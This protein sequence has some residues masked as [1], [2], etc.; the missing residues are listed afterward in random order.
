MRKV[1]VK[2]NQSIYDIAAAEY[3]SLDAVGLILLDNAAQLRPNTRLVPGMVLNIRE[4]PLDAVRQ[5]QITARGI[6]P[7]NGDAYRVEEWRQVWS[8]QFTNIV[9]RGMLPPVWGT[10]GSNLRTLNA[11][12]E[13]VT[14]GG[15]GI[16]VSSLILHDNQVIISRS[17]APL[18]IRGIHI[19][20]NDLLPTY[21]GNVN[22]NVTLAIDQVIIYDGEVLALVA[23]QLWKGAWTG[24]TSTLAS[25]SGK[26]GWRHMT[27]RNGLLYAAT[28][29]GLVTYDGSTYTTIDMTDGLPSN[30]LKHVLVDGRGVVWVSTDHD[31]L[32]RIVN[33]NIITNDIT[34]RFVPTDKPRVMAEDDFGRVLVAFEDDGTRSYLAVIDTDN[35]WR[36]LDSSDGIIPTGTITA[37]G[38]D[39]RN[40]VYVGT[41]TGLHYWNRHPIINI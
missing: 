40:N 39:N 8:G 18:N 12:G 41:A 25:V 15:T 34:G 7:A 21:V 17:A 27:Q 2:E 36:V 33:G 1:T 32:V 30:D 5:R 28:D 20:T 38:V 4:T 11:A 9:M 35:I 14:I 16:T 19:Y 31:G 24:T 13:V 26:T 22:A 23:G 3:G 6:E 29:A 37:L 10:V